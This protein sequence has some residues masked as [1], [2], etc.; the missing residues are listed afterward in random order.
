[1]ESTSFEIRH[2]KGNKNNTMPEHHDI[3]LKGSDESLITVW[4]ENALAEEVAFFLDH[5]KEF[6]AWVEQQKRSAA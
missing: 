5:R 1:M 3:H 2:H 4:A 6:R